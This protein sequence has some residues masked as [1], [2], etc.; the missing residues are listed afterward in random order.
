M[1][2][3]GNI[4]R[5]D[6]VDVPVVPGR[7]KLRSLWYTSCPITGSQCPHHSAPDGTLQPVL[8]NLSI[9]TH[10]LSTAQGSGTRRGAPS[11]AGC[12]SG[13]V[14]TPR[15]AAPGCRGTGCSD[16]PTAAR[17]RRPRAPRR[18]LRNRWPSDGKAGDD[19]RAPPRGRARPRARPRPRVRAAEH[20]PGRREPR[21]L[22]DGAHRVRMVRGAG[23]GPG[24]A[25]REGASRGARAAYRHPGQDLPGGWG[26]LF[27]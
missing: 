8:H 2:P 3:R 18:R 13:L 1:P 10:K 25:L 4:D 20:A 5:V 15:P 27:V 12:A 16:R 6:R 22:V 24:V 9:S 7:A 23:S 21:R 26:V 14:S 11:A 19:G 17:D